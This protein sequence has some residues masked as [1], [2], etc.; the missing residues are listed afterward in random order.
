MELKY[1]TIEITVIDSYPL[2]REGLKRVLELDTDLRIV[3]EGE[4]GEELLSLYEQHQPD[5]VLIEANL[6]HK[7]GIEALQKLLH[8]FPFAKVL[9][10]TVID[11]FSYVSQA[12]KGG[13]SGYLLKE[14]DA[15]MIGGAIK[16]VVKGGYY[17]HPKIAKNFLME[18]NKLAEKDDHG[19]FLQTVIQRP[20]HLLT[21]RECV[22]LQLLADGHSNKTLGERLGISDKTVKN[23]VS[24]ILRKMNLQDR[25]Q[26]VVTAIKNGWVELK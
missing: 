19:M 20:D 16:T 5:V 24:A 22:V 15:E 14:M 10:F 11:D 26:V 8:H 9:F 4:T 3:A 12:L 6:P 13:A 21:A 2:F 18:F 7:N 23:H 25:T 17:L 1:K